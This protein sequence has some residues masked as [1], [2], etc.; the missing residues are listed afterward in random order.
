MDVDT[1]RRIH[2]YGATLSVV[3]IAV[4]AVAFALRGEDSF[5]GTVFGLL[6]PLGAFYFVGAVL[7]DTSRYR[8][9]G[10]ELLRGVVWYGGSLFGWSLIVTSSDAVPATPVTAFGLPALTALGLSLAMVGLRR[11]T[12]LELT[13]QTEGGQL[14]VAITG[15]IVGGFVV[16]YLVLVE[17][18][19]PWLGPVYVLA[20][21]AGLAL[22]RY[23]W[24]DEPSERTGSA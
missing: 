4:A 16:G 6:G 13:V 23:H 7:Q 14:L 12:G 8:V 2:R 11:L 5:V 22:W 20:T 24:R 9:L 15:A 1:F 17:G 21:V 18:R 3:A 19:S 10:D